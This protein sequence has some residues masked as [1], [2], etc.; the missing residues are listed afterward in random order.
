MPLEP[1]KR[2]Q[3]TKLIKYSHNM[4][5]KDEVARALDPTLIVVN[6]VVETIDD[7]ESK[8]ITAAGLSSLQTD[9]L[10]QR[11]GT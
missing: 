10:N 5:T 3:K 4:N 7:S 1:S 6:T 11:G 8:Q 9:R 2:I